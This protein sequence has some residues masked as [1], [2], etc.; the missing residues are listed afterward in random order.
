MI[1]EMQERLSGVCVCVCMCVSVVRI[2][3]CAYMDDIGGN[4]CRKDSLVCACMYICIYVCMCVFIVHVHIQ[5]IHTS[6][7]VI[8][9]IFFSSAHVRI[10]P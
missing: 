1:H 2:L 4:R 3:V 5:N 9:L 6:P 7:Q 8:A 10:Y